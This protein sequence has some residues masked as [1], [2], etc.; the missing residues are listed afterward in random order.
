MKTVGF[1]TLGCKANQY[2]SEAMLEAFR[3]AGYAPREFHEFCDVYLVN[4]CVVTGTGES[5]SMKFVRQAF[6]K[7]PGAEIIVAGCMAQQKGEKLF[8]PGVRLVLGNARRGEV[9]ALLEEAIAQGVSLCAVENLSSQPFEN[10]EIEASEGHSRAM[11]KIQEGCENHCSYCIIPSVRGPLRSRPLASIRAEARRLSG[12]GFFEIVATGIHLSSY[13]LDLRDGSTLLDAV[14]AL[15]EAPGLRRI[16]LGSLEPGFITRESARALSAF[17]KLC[18]QFHLSLQSGS[19]GV[20]KRMR[21]QYGTARFKEAVAALREFF[22]GCAI[23]SDLICGFPGESEEDFLKTL[24]FCQQIGFSRLHVFPYSRREGTPAASFPGQLPKALRQARAHA[25]IA[26]GEE[27]ENAYAQSFVGKQV[28]V[29]CEEG[30]CGY[31]R[32][33]L[34]LRFPPGPKPGQILRA[35]VLSAS[36]PLLL[37]EEVPPSGPT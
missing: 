37:G 23:T 27:L 29:L 31:T 24:A 6:R 11:L 17:E 5:K 26:L 3:R 16:R 15:H 7:N 8:L 20:L 22:P 13:G 32:E 10:L 4:S 28:E 36:G 9:V 21:R 14:S 19:D 25:L 1:M 30:G 34:R 12:A 33:Y 18:P 35:R 2:D